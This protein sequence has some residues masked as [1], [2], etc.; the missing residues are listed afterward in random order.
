MKT[1]QEKGTALA[2]AAERRRLSM[3][4]TAATVPGLFGS[5]VDGHFLLGSLEFT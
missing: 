4:G 3:L 1:W 2:T 5:L